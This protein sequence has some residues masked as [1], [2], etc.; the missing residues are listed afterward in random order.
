[1]LIIPLQPVYAQTLHVSLNGQT[2]IITLRQR[3]TGLYMDFTL[4]TVVLFTEV[5][6]RI[7]MLMLHQP[8]FGFSG[9]LMFIDTLGQD[10]PDSSALG[11]RWLLVYLDPTDLAGVGA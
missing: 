7:S 6:C 9:D 8:S 11:S 5:L 2:C 10:D 4:G 3:T 1:M